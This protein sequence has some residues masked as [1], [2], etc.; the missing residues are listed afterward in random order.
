[1]GG[2]SELL[3]LY[4]LDL[5]VPGSETLLLISA[6]LVGRRAGLGAACGILLATA[7][8]KLVAL[9]GLAAVANHLPRLLFVMRILG[10]VVFVLFA[11]MLFYCGVVKGTAVDY[12]RRSKKNEFLTW[13]GVGFGCSFVNPFTVA[14]TM[15]LVAVTTSC[16]FSMGQAMALLSLML[17]LN[18]FWDLIIIFFGRKLIAPLLSKP[19][20]M[21]CIYGGVAIV[22]ASY[23]ARFLH[24]IL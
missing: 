13:V 8:Y 24:E 9:L 14:A 17:A 20:I 2:I 12:V 16:M 3:T 6:A 1:V 4:A 15:A 11:A 10:G 21:K 18:L 7:M 5:L 22:F 19:L 23:G